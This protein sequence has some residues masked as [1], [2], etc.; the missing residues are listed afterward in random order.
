MFFFSTSCLKF[1]AIVLSATRMQCICSV[2][3]TRLQCKCCNLSAMQHL[4]LFYHQ[5]ATALSLVPAYNVPPS[6]L[7]ACNKTVLSAMSSCNCPVFATCLLPACKANA[8]SALQQPCLCY[9][10]GRNCTVLVAHLQCNP[11]LAMQ[12]SCR[13]LFFMQLPCLALRLP[14]TILRLG[15]PPAML[16]L[17]LGD[18][19]ATR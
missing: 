5:E 9:S 3:A 8:L 16:P 12:L 6:K 4:C 7:P 14:C 2:S 15:D 18:P 17:C 11:P 10:L 1:K 13:P 19:P